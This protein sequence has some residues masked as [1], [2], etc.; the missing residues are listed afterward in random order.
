MVVDSRPGCFK[1]AFQKTKQTNQLGGL[2]IETLSPVEV[3]HDVDEA[4][5]GLL[6]I[7]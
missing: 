7:L 4:V 5:E 3:L 6:F 2:H 1:H